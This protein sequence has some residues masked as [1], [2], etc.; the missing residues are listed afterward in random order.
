M[1][2]IG[3]RVKGTNLNYKPIEGTVI[4]VFNDA[5]ASGTRD[6]VQI[7]HLQVV[8]DDGVSHEMRPRDISYVFPVEKKIREMK[9]FNVLVVTAA[10]IGSLLGILL[11]CKF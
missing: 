3:R 6:Y 5:L 2:I 4:L 10:I 9:Y 8:T 1:S 11:A 7:T